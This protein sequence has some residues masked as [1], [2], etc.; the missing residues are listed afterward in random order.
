MDKGL[1]ERLS[2]IQIWER[3]NILEVEILSICNLWQNVY[4]SFEDRCKFKYFTKF[5]STER[6]GWIALVHAFCI[7][8][9]DKYP[10]ANKLSWAINK[11][12]RGSLGSKFAL[13]VNWS[14][15]LKQLLP[16]SR[17]IF[18]PKLYISYYHSPVPATLAHLHLHVLC[19]YVH[20]FVCLFHFLV[21]LPV[22]C[23]CLFVWLF[24]LLFGL[25]VGCVCCICFLH[26]LVSCEE[27]QPKLIYNDGSL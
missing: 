21:S 4:V 13:S 1:V 23:I 27:C 11:V 8:C 10:N 18:G 9:V 3:L 22:C 12:G 20:L 16:I 6:L 26:L 17:F 24:V 2:P 7:L 25:F 14:N 5:C 19:M 15:F